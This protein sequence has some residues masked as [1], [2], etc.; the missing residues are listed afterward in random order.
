MDLGIVAPAGLGL[1]VGLLLGGTAVWV[2]AQARRQRSEQELREQLVRVDEQ[3][4]AERA[5]AEQRGA[6]LATAERQLGHAF[7]ALA[8]DALRKNTQS[9]LE[10]AKASLSEHVHTASSDLERRQQAIDGLVRPLRDSIT[11]VD[12]RLEAVEKQRIEHFTAIDEHLKAMA[13][14]QQE[15]ESETRNLVRA[16][17]SPTVQGRWGELQLRRVVELA[18]MLPHCD[19]TEQTSQETETGRMR[20]DMIV[21]LPGNKKV[22]VDAKAPLQAYL[23][24][25]EASDE[26][27]RKLDLQSHARQVRQHMSSLASRAYWEQFDAAPDFVV[28]FLPGET[29]FSAALEHD[30][31][32]IEYGV[33]RKV[34]PASPTTLIA[35]LRAVA[36]GWNQES[37]AENAREISHLGR[38]LYDR[39]QRFAG[40]FEELRKG[41]DRAVGS[42]NRAVGSLESRVLVSARRLRELGVGSGAIEPATPIVSS[43]RAFQPPGG[44]PAA[45]EEP[46]P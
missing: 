34:I 41:L 37:L 25:T 23:N 21:H 44:A 15:L 17:R 7:E 43:P 42:Y 10:L 26:E 31:T 19:F 28:M 36:Y 35:L 16:L 4:R 8:S 29:F 32:L 22:V 30:P 39:V 24:A 5:A 2:G 14:S 13:R 12:T 11:R 3:L 20:P 40:H 27:R 18:G 33:E 38:Q 6:L 46:D 45:E 1:V 9:F